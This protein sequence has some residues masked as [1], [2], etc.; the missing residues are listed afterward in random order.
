MKNSIKLAAGSFLAAA[1]VVSGSAALAGEGG[2]AGSVAAKL[3]L[4]G[5]VTELSSSIATG[6]NAAA[7]TGHTETSGTFTSAVG[8]AGVL[9]VTNANSTTAGYTVAAD[10]T[11]GTAQANSLT[12]GG[13]IDVGNSTLELP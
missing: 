7:T 8:G 4:L 3:G 11:L 12:G 9:T 5:N 1:F 2:S 10:G 6:K 13:T